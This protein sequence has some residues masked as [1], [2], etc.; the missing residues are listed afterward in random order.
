MSAT[1][2]SWGKADGMGRFRLCLAEL[3]LTCSGPTR[4]EGGVVLSVS[5]GMSV[6][7]RRLSAS[8]WR[9]IVEKLQI[10]NG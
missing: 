9:H 10:Y 8:L 2:S 7:D 3:T 1:F 6:H 5:V 4:W